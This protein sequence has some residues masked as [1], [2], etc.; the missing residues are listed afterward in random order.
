[1]YYFEIKSIFSRKWENYPKS[2]LRKKKF[3]W[4]EFFRNIYETMWLLVDTTRCDFVLIARNISI[5][6]ILP[7]RGFAGA[8]N[9]YNVT[10]FVRA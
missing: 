4:S 9:I 10:S 6:N 1:M 7:F 8:F 5:L 2:I 3:H